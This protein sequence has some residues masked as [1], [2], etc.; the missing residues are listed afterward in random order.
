VFA[1][2]RVKVEVLAALCAFLTAVLQAILKLFKAFEGAAAA[3]A[4]A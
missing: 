3:R 1:S 4:A 2:W